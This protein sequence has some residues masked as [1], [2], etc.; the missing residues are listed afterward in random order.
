MVSQYVIVLTMIRWVLRTATHD[1]LRFK[2]SPWSPINIYDLRDS[3]NTTLPD[4]GSNGYWLWQYNR[5][6]SSNMYFG[7]AYWVHPDA[8]FSEK[9]PQTRGTL[10]AASVSDRIDEGTVA[11]E[12][13]APLS[14][15]NGHSQRLPPFDS[16]WRRTLTDLP[17]PPRMHAESK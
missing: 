10:L 15:K 6:D 5:L 7:N 13:G 16:L 1:I 11:I 17:L 4:R 8:M 14:M 3:I 2:M 9:Y 12:Y